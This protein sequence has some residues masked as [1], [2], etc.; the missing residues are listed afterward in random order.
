MLERL[1]HKIRRFRAFCSLAGTTRALA[2]E[3]AWSLRRQTISLRLR[4]YPEPFLIRRFSSDVNVFSQVFVE[5][6][7][8]EFL[9]E[10]PRLIVDGGANV[11]YTTAFYANRFP[12]AQI[13]SVEPCA[14][15]CEQLRRN[16][17]CFRNVSVIQGALWTRRATLRIA[18][19]DAPDWAFKVEECEDPGED[20]LEGC[21][22]QDIL[23]QS[24]YSRIDLLKLDIEGAEELLFSQDNQGWLPLVDAM[25]IEI[26]GSK[27]GEVIDSAVSEPEFRRTKSG[28]KTFFVRRAAADCADS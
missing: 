16:C 23:E 25:A 7:L 12:A 4:D 11:G 26:H 1:R 15:N 8:E 9:P 20:T 22:I 27:A 18:N 10:S 24:G 19:P 3:L 6:D 21:S 2:F 17:R 5:R 28:D 14:S 13:I